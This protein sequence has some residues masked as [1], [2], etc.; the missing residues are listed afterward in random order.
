MLFLRQP[1]QPLLR[2]QPLGV[3]P[4]VSPPASSTGRLAAG[5]VPS[6]PLG[7]VA[8]QFRE[9]AV[10]LTPLKVLLPASQILPQAAL[11]RA[12]LLPGV[13]RGTGE[14]AHPFPKPP[15]CSLA[16]PPQHPPRLVLALF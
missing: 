13:A 15:A 11:H 10:T 5:Q 9:H 4:P 7:D 14:L 1:S 16:R 6:Q 8:I 3:F 2:L 12:P